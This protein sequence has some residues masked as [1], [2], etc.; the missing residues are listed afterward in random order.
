MDKQIR[1][2]GV[3]DIMRASCVFFV[4]L[5]CFVLSAC[6]APKIQIFQ[7]GSVPL[8]EFTLQG[9]EESKILI[10]PV[11]GIISDVPDEG[12]LYTKPSMVQDVVSQI[13]LAEKDPHVRAIVLKVE[14][15]GG[16]ITA[17]DILYHEITELKKRTKIKVI[18]AMMGVVASGG[19]YISLP[20]DSILAHPTTVTGSIGVIF[21]GPKVKG[22]MD[23]IGVDME[24]T[25]SGVNKDMGSPFRDSTEYEKIILEEMIDALAERFSKLVLTHRELKKNRLD[26]VFSA[27]VF[28]AKDALQIG[29]VDKIGYLDDA[30]LEAQKLAGLP[31]D[32]K[33]VVYRRTEYPDDNLYNSMTNHSMAGKVSL[34]DLGLE[35]DFTVS[36]PGFYYLW[37][38]AIGKY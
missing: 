25:K 5:T 34:I 27:R 23:K 8:Q 18:V 11:R 38:P 2:S 21:M 35:N 17:S 31:K 33:V 7:D 29:L 30:L 15:P 13:R 1:H 36:D 26:E 10:I 37:L 14:S 3:W 9:K 28:L 4:T 32:S 24:V 20:A 22:L 16:S 19:Y 6:T 12:L